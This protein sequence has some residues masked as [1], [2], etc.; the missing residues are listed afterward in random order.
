MTTPA[1]HTIGE[2]VDLLVGEFPDVSVSKIRFLESEGL[3]N[4]SRS[5]SGY[6]EFGPADVERV[7]YVLRQQRDHFLPL[8]VIRSKLSAWERGEGPTSA[9]E[10]GPPPDAYFGASGVEMDTDEVARSAGA[11]V[12]LVD[13]L[14][15][16]GILTPTESDL[17]PR[18]DE[19][20]ITV[21][22]AAHRLMGHGLEARHLRALRLGANR[23]VDLFRQLTGH[24]LRNPSPANVRSAGEV[25]ADCAQAARELQE[26]L[27]RADLRKVLDV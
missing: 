7:R 9:P 11:P 4:P 17:G 23:E 18:F 10:P 3:I 16:H 20:A 15:S 8:K 19:D 24:L 6:R 27:V 2:V 14:V 5:T 13:Q 22:R 12:G 25:L 21:V 26:A 1:R